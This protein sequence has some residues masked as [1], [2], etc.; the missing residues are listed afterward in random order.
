VIGF[1]DYWLGGSDFATPNAFVWSGTGQRVS[2]TDWHSGEPNH[3]A[4]DACIM[5]RFNDGYLKWNDDR[6]YAEYNIIC[7]QV[8]DANC[9]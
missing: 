1:I 6:P 7:E 8:C 9:V 2:F 4:G 5:Y 3:D